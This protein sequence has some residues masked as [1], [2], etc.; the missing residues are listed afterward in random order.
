MKND[1]RRSNTAKLENSWAANQSP[2]FIWNAPPYSSNTC[3]Y[4]SNSSCYA[5]EIKSNNPFRLW[6]M[7]NFRFHSIRQRPGGAAAALI[8]FPFNIYCFWDFGQ[9][10]LLQDE[11]ECLHNAWGS[12]SEAITSLILKIRDRH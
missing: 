5:T 7:R 8:P 2:V 10:I 6:T 4:I 3:T 11:S 1:Y 9:D 12:V